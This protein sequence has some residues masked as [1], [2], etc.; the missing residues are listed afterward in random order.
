MAAPKKAKNT[1]AKT[2]EQTLWEA[3]DKMRGNLEAGEHKHVFLGLV[4]LKYVY[5]AFEERRAWL[6][7]VT[8][9]PDNNDYYVPKADRRPSIIQDRN[10]YTSQNVFWVPAE[11]RWGW[12]QDRAKQHAFGVLID[13]AMDLIEAENPTLK[14]IAHELVKA[15]RASATI[16]WNLKDSVRAE[17]RAKVRRLLTRYDY[18]PDKEEKAIDLVLQQAELF[19]AEAA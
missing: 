18:P 7:A 14:Q 3:A 5:D 19:V 11:A 16:D 1:P 12:L 13:K 9:D 10:E 8:A 6:E 17:M 4:F 2:L 15:G